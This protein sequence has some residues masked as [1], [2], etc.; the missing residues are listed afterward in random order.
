MYRNAYILY[1]LVLSLAGLGGCS[2]QPSGKGSGKAATA[3]DKIQ[4]KA[5]IALNE[6]F[7]PSLLN[8]SA[9]GQFLPDRLDHHHVLFRSR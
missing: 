7:Q 3:P 1:F 5:Q 4:G 2:S 6:S 8:L 9:G